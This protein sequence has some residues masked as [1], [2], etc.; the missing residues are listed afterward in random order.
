[1]IRKI[2]NTNDLNRIK[3]EKDKILKTFLKL[4]SKKYH[5]TK[6]LPLKINFD[7][8]LQFTNCTITTAKKMW[9]NNK[10]K[11]YIT[12]Q[13]ALRTNTFI[14]HDE[15]K[16]FKW[17]SELTMLGGFVISSDTTIENELKNQFLFLNEIFSE[18]KFIIKITFN[19]LLVNFFNL[20]FLE[21]FKNEENKIIVKLEKNND[22]VWK[23][24][25]N[26]FKGLGTSWEIINTENNNRYAFGN[27]IAIFDE[28]K[29][30]G[31]EFG[32][33]AEILVQAKMNL[34]SKIFASD[35]FYNLIFDIANLTDN[36]KLM[37][38]IITILTITKSQINK[39][40][41]KILLKHTLFSYYK[42]IFSFLNKYNI[43]LPIF[44]TYLKNALKKL[45]NI[46][47]DKSETNFWKYFYYFQ[48]F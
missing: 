30:V 46:D 42:T 22:L 15:N 14:N 20:N 12:V 16:E 3:I 23:Y 6:P 47:C 10:N 27:V 9:I 26:N 28:K 41:T 17:N 32:G 35:S 25:F 7:P 11:S 2:L 18:K 37:D 4:Y 5:F 36:Y 31:F 33:G 40:N 39:M 19:S 29:L 43:E 48:K 1:M 21:I 24:G 34:D 45:E 13:K 44:Q 38:A 8:T